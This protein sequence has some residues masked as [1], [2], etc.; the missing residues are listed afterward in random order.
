MTKKFSSKKP[1]RMLLLTV[2]IT[3]AVGAILLA[4]PMSQKTAIPFIDILFTSASLTCVTGLLTV[5]LESFSSFGQ[6]IIFLLMQ[7]GG[8][9]LM[10][11][12]LIIVSFFANMGLSTQLIASQILEIDKLRNIRKTFILIFSLTAIVETLG[13]IAT[14][15]V[16]KDS[17]NFK[18]AIFYSFFHSVSSFCSCGITLFKNGFEKFATNPTMLLTTALLMLVGGLGFVVWSEIFKF[19]R[20]KV[21]KKNKFFAFS[22]HSK[23]IFSFTAVLLVVASFIFLNLETNNTLA[24][25]TTFEKI[26]NSIFTA[27]SIRSTG[28]L[29]VSFAGLQLAT[30]LFMMVM[31][32]IGTSPGSTGSGIKTTVF[33]IFL[34]TIKSVLSGRKE[35]EIYGRTISHAQVYKSLSIITISMA[36]IITTAFFLLITE[37]GFSFLDIIFETASAFVNLGIS[38]GITPELSIIGKSF[39]IITMIIGRIGSLTLALAFLKG[40][41]RIDFSYPEEKV[42]LS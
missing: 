40:P 33:A 11:M 6:T 28:F 9:G 18:D 15:F 36:W 12:S 42:M 37:K 24:G 38:P 10:T 34:A 25:M 3:I 21:S 14:F 39:L 32:F 4:L 26:Y 2:F 17:Y 16:I 1:G 8:L 13:A 7:I 22:L 23:I 19:I 27:V 30:I 41:D 5:P 20:S 29:T 35:V 31:S